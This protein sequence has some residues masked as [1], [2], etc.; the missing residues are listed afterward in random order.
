MDHAH[1][2]RIARLLAG[3]RSPVSRRAAVA[4]LIAPLAGAGFV[5]PAEAKRCVKH[6][7]RCTESTVCCGADRCRKGVC[8]CGVGSVTCGARCFPLIRH[9][10]Q[11]GACDKAPGTTF[12]ADG[13][14]RKS[15]VAGDTICSCDAQCCSNPLPSRCLNGRCCLEAGAGCYFGG[16]AVCCS[17]VC[18]DNV[19]G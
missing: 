9:R 16:D 6:G 4:A 15:A 13:Y 12:C 19:C 17:G 2:D 8:A 5:H 11:P 7:A 3:N 1:F 10:N 18:R 14:C